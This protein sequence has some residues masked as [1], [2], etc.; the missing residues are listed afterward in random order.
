MVR[1]TGIQVVSIQVESV[2][3]DPES[4][5]TR[6]LKW[7][8]EGDFDEYWAVVDVDDH[9]TLPRAIELAT[10]RMV[11]LAISNPS[12]ELWLLWHYDDCA[13]HRHRKDLEL[14][15]RHHG[16]VAKALPA[17]F[18]FHG[19]AAASRRA[20]S[21]APNLDHSVKGPNPS[22]SVHLLVARIVAAGS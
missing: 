10:E 1:A 19:H 4:V 15:L 20:R 14:S 8:A 5:V 3:K 2:G 17:A 21:A 6:T 11:P 7:I 12:F 16:H 9:A 18:P 22:S 13:G